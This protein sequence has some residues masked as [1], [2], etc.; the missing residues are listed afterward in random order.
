MQLLAVWFLEQFE[1][2]KSRKSIN[3]AE[4]KPQDLVCGDFV[5]VV[6]P[7]AFTNITYRPQLTGAQT[8]AKLTLVSSYKS[9]LRRN[10]P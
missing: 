6:P 2:F 1:L 4:D 9:L 8:Q 10:R 5:V 7:Q 3:T